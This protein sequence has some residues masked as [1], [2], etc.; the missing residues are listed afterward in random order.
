MNSQKDLGRPPTQEDEEASR[1]AASG[2][3]R[4]A[5]LAIARRRRRERTG[6]SPYL[7]GPLESKD[8]DPLNRYGTTRGGKL[9]DSQD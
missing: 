1:W 6:H 5:I 2:T 8:Q 7:V 3:L 4:D 9:F